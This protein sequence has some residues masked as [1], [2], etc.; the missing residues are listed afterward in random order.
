MTAVTASVASSASSVHQ[1]AV[2]KRAASIAAP[3]M[4]GTA[5]SGGI[6]SFLPE[7]V[8]SR[9][10]ISPAIAPK[11][12]TLGP[13]PAQSAPA[14]TGSESAATATTI[15]TPAFISSSGRKG[16]TFS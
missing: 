11:S 12:F 7:K 4:T 15:I 13:S 16:R 8:G 14:E 5:H 2:V 3:T 10:T 1:V 6:L 9:L